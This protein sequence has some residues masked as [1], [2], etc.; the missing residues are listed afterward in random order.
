[1]G[2][3]GLK[4]LCWNL[5]WKRNKVNKDSLFISFPSSKCVKIA[6]LATLL[7][8]VIKQSKRKKEKENHTFFLNSF[9][10]DEIDVFSELLW[11]LLVFKQK[12]KQKVLQR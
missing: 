7:I 12:H 8:K 9:S 2:A 1:M 3:C 6:R 4:K 11:V 10:V 5:Y